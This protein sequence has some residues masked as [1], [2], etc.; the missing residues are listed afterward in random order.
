[1]NLSMHLRA[2]V[3]IA[4]VSGI[5]LSGCEG[6]AGPSVGSYFLPQAII[7]VR[8]DKEEATRKVRL[9]VT[10]FAQRHQLE[11]YRV[12]DDPTVPPAVR[13]DPWHA[14]NTE[15]LPA[16]DTLGF[17]LVLVEL[18]SR[19]WAIQLHERTGN[20]TRASVNAFHNLHRS[21]Q[22]TLPGS[23]QVIVQPTR[24]QNWASRQRRHDAVDPQQ[25]GALEDVCVRMGLG[26]VPH[27]E[28]TTLNVPSRNHSQDDTR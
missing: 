12:S 7:G 27:L 20:W 21:L 13:E 22:I 1:M 26:P 11:K 2:L 14:R 25:P 19:C 16:E 6:A 18:S 10:E 28:P 5:V 9:V 3:Q 15:Y 17:D 8:L 24:D 23:A 4:A